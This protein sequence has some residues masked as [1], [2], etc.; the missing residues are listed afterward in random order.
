MHCDIAVTSPNALQHIN[1]TTTKGEYN[2][3]EE[4]KRCLNWN[5]NHTAR[6]EHTSSVETSSEFLNV[7]EVVCQRGAVSMQP[8][9]QFLSQQTD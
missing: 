2:T 1:I 5:D 6:H 7:F 8:L 4:R 9:L 3:S